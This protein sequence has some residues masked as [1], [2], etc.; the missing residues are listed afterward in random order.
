MMILTSC[1]VKS[2][3]AKYP[4][5]AIDSYIKEY[6]G[7]DNNIPKENTENKIPAESGSPLGL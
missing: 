7:H 4:S 5:E 3:P 2:P 1:G 6:T